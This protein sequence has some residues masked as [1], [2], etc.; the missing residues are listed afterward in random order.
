[1]R[2]NILLFISLCVVGCAMMYAQQR[3]GVLQKA[4]AD[5][6]ECEEW[7]DE[8]LSEVSVKEERGQLYIHT[9]GPLYTQRKKNKM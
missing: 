3:H 9:A 2:R 6:Q 4:K 8:Y 7:V 5:T 1:M